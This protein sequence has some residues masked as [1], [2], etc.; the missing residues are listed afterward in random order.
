LDI[1]CKNNHLLSNKLLFF[2]FFSI[3]GQLLA[4]FKSEKF[5]RII[6][7]DIFAISK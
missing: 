3:G 1:F 7:V 5:F 4:I 6:F 2:G